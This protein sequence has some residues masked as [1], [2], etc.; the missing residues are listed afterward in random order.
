MENF[1]VIELHQTRDFS[2]KMNATFEFIK[3]NF[4]PLTKSI[5]FIAGPPIL[6]A[7]MLIGSLV[8]DLFSTAQLGLVNDGDM[9]M[10]RFTSFNFWLQM[11]VIMVFFL[12]SSVT[13][14]ATV[15]NYIILYGERKSNQIEFQDV[16]ERVRSTFWMYLGTMFLFTLTLIVVYIVLILPV[17]LLAAISPW[18]I[19][20]GVMI[21]M[22]GA[23]YLTVGASLVFFIR[24][25]ER[26]GFFNSLFRSYKLVQG[27]WW[28]TFGLI[29]V[30]YMIVGTIAYFFIIPW[31]AYM[32]TSSLHSLETGAAADPGTGFQII[33]MI[34]FALYYLVQMVLYS[35]PNVGIA[36]QYFNLVEMKEAR[37]LLDQIDSIGQSPAP[38]ASSDEH[39]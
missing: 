27:K 8:G 5:L 33:T 24:G 35:L 26:G 30:L 6:V 4:K 31:Y 29:M 38:A 18:L 17:T 21:F 11:I 20:F 2:K 34:F 9:F 19:F 32:L 14:V 16:W 28:S 37:G 3:Q 13:T 22:G 12:V 36:F 1:K 23:M 25:Y 39:Y 7:S 15:N 10:E